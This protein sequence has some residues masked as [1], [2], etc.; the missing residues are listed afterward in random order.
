MRDKLLEAQDLLRHAV[1]SG[2]L[3]EIV[4]R[5]LTV[6]LKELK[7]KKYAVTDKPRPSEGPRPGSRTIAATVRRPVSR[8]DDERCGFVSAGRRK[9][10]TRAYVQ[11]HHV[12]PYAMGGEATVERTEL[13]CRAH[14]EYE[15]ELFYG[16]PWWERGPGKNPRDRRR[17]SRRRS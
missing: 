10:N 4:E 1:P 13:R 3:G 6:L 15:A 14:N 12:D 17:S 7:R 9:C 8:R 16:R 11:F 2:D 5:A